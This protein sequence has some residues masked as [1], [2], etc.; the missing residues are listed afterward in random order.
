MEMTGNVRFPLG[1]FPVVIR[2]QLYTF[3]PPHAFELETCDEE[4]GTCVAALG[5]G[6]KEAFTPKEFS[7]ALDE[8][9]SHL[10]RVDSW[11]LQQGYACKRDE[12]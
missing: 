1:T 8:M 5:S 7:D 10:A 12:S 3:A 11:M 9:M 4:D 2:D 6:P